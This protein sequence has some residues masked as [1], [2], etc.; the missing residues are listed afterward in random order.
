MKAE[1]TYISVGY[2]AVFVLAF[3]SFLK[4]ARL[5]DAAPAIWWT[6]C[7]MHLLL[8]AL[9]FFLSRLEQ[10][11]VKF[12]APVNQVESKRRERRIISLCALAVCVIGTGLLYRLY[13]VTHPLKAAQCMRGILWAPVFF[14]IWYPFGIATATAQLWLKHKEMKA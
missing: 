14:L 13:N 5:Q 1:K 3:L 2:I 12:L 4:A 7:S 10:L 9:V 6:V 11:L 8:W